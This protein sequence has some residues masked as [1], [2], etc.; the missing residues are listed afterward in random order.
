MASRRSLRLPI[1]LGVLM[2]LL[3]VM[4]TVGWIVLGVKGILE[5]ESVTFYVTLLTLG[6]TFLMLILVGVAIYL[7]MSVKAI[8]LNQR[9]S[10]FIDSV[11]HELKSPIASLKLYLQTLGRRSVDDEQRA[12]FYRIMLEDVER[13][14]QLINHLLEAASLEKESQPEPPERIPLAPLLEEAVASLCTRH[15]VSPNCVELDLQPVALSAR[16]VDLEMIFRNLIDNAI[17]YSGTPPHVSVSLR[18]ERER[19]IVVCVRDNGA[20]IPTQLRRKIFGRFVRLGSELERKKPGT[21]LG[22]YIVRT[23]VERMKG[24]VRVRDADRQ[25]GTVFEVR[26]PG[27]EAVTPTAPSMTLA[28]T[29]APPE[30]P[31]S[32][33]SEPLR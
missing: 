28:E 26:L 20:G 27:G 7:S 31:S 18:W 21:G 13:L 14:D 6:T 29:A 24:R 25:G 30:P 2:I 12:S 23:L 8:N 33:P 15:H 16:R 19:M 4:L 1:S 17:K 9:Q 10:N 11:T 5:S 22:L 32:S 3:V